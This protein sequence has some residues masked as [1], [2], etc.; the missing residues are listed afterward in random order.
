METVKVSTEEDTSMEVS[1]TDL[2]QASPGVARVFDEQDDVE[3]VTVEFKDGA[4]MTF[5]KT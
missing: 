1:M 5:T 2:S 3:E 4:S